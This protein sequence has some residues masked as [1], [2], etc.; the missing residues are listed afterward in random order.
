M[1]FLE[2]FLGL[3]ELLAAVV[4]LVSLAAAMSKRWRLSL[5]LLVGTS[6]IVAFSR[7]QGSPAFHW[8]VGFHVI[9][10]FLMLG[11]FWES[12]RGKS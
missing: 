11:L 7:V 2:I 3:L 6:A 10:A 1:G 4:D 9:I 5:S 8:L 12:R